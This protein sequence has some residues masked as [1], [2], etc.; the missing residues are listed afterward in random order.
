M[1][2]IKKVWSKDTI[3]VHCNSGFKVMDRVGDLPGYRTVYYKPTGIANILSR[4][5]A[6]K[7][8][9]VIFNSEGGN[10]FRMVLPDSEVRCQLSPN[11]LY[12][13]NAADRDNSVLL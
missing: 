11:G 2:N 10:F 4:S 9:R 6:T 3:C 5:G 1:L 12:Y 13:L 7:K 8:F